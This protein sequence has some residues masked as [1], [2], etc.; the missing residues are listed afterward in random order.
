MD[1]YDY[2]LAGTYFV[3]IVTNQRRC[4]LSD[5]EDGIV[6]LLPAGEIALDVWRHLPEHFPKLAL[7]DIVIMPNHIHA[8]LIL[9]DATQAGQPFQGTKTVS[10]AATPLSI[11]VGEWKSYTTRRVNQI[12]GSTCETLWQRGFFDRI[13]R[14]QDE[15]DRLA[16]YISVNPQNWNKDRD[17]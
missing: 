15:W 8:I 13:V 7:G 10:P 1:G 12:D 9:V 17:Y 3:T 14:D 4:V 6:K 2:H 16:A 5:I 11:I